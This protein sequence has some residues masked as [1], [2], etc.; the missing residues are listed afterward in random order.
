MSVRVLLVDD[1]T[2]VRQGLRGLLALEPRVEVVGEAGDVAS[3][4][5]AIVRLAPDV[6]LLDVVLGDAS[7]FDVVRGARA[8]GC[9]PAY[10]VVTTYDADEVFATSIREGA[11]G[12]LLKDSSVD[13]L[14]DALLAV[15]RG[16]TA[17]R[18]AVTER[19]RARAAQAH[20]AASPVGRPTAREREILRLLAAGYANREIAEVLGVAEGTVKNHVTHLLAKLGVRDRTRAVLRAIELRWL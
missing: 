8:R 7:G 15:A 14:V 11:R 13:V 20:E 6:V 5:T 19:A 3:A 4:V 18:P 10:V 1:H 17:F 16:E 12:F 9:A 2:L